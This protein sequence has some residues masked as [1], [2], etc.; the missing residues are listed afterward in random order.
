MVNA[1]MIDE[2]DDV[3]VAIEPIEKGSEI[4][5]KSKDDMV[6]TLIALDNII[7]YHKIA[8]KDIAKGNPISKYGEHIGVAATDIKAGMHVHEHN[9]QSVREEL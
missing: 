1:L 2:K 9:V 3:I 4:N 7:I 5:Y 6:K 8:V